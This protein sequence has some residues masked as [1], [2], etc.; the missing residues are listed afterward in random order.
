MNIIALIVT[1]LATIKYLDSIANRLYL[2][3]M[4][5]SDSIVEKLLTAS[6]KVTAEQL[7]SMHDQVKTTKK[8]LADL[9][10]SS[11]LTTEAELT[12]F[13]AQEVDVPYVDL[14]P[15]EIDSEILHTVPE[16]TAK[17]YRVV[18]FGQTPSGAKK[19]AIEDPDDVQAVNFL[20]KTF[21]SNLQLY[22]ANSS[23]ISASLDL[24]RGNI[25][26]ELIKVISNDDSSEPVE[27]EVSEADVAEDSPI[28]QTVNLLIEDAVKQGASDIHIEPR[29]L[30]VL[31][32][33]RVDGMLREANKLPKKVHN[34]LVSRI[35]ILSNLKIDERRAP[36]DGRF[37]V[38][39]GG[40]VYAMRVS[41]LPVA[42]GE[43]VAMRILNESSKPSTLQELGFWGTSLRAIN[44][45]ITKP[46]GMVLVTG[47]TG[48]GKSTSLFSILSILNKPAVNISTIEDPI[49]YR[50]PGTN[51]TQVNPVAHMTFASG[52][53]ALLRQD[54]NIIM[55]GEIRDT[56]TAGLAVQAALTGHLVFSTLHTNNAA[57]SLP[58]LLDMGVEA[59]LIASTVRAVVG[60]RLVRKLCVDCRQSY[61][62][63]SAALAELDDVFHINNPDAIAE[64]HR[65]ESE[66]R[67][68]GIG[69]ISKPKSSSTVDRNARR[70]P[71]PAQ[72]DS[73][74]ADTPLGTSESA[75]T[76]LWQANA[77][78][79]QTC[80]HTGFK[81]RIGIYEV[82][83]NSPSIQK[84]IIGNHSS[85]ELQAQAISEGMLPIQMDGLI[86]ALRGMT[87]IEEILRVTAEA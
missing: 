50:I 2:F 51:Q 23:A 75:I 21:G 48:S 25:S 83:D 15:L 22:V 66:A 5:I 81:G 41:T 49:E 31:V 85:E 78:G 3:C 11:N 26:S 7:A 68:A 40:H 37:K 54:P 17:Q 46:H 62:P 58:R 1:H 16:R 60:Q 79:C 12:R 76:T 19:L 71:E 67:A 14:N 38:E 42:D 35:K 34:A 69:A 28:A 32:R 24:Y 18:A 87:T 57:T 74:L 72:N 29:D 10:V 30:L 52:L 86:K 4:H 56:E 73:Q 45:S 82:L 43:K 8:S 61:A 84:L 77:E 33:Y 80:N 27:Q 64:L 55:V 44:K 65:L 13:Y 36:Q 59:F 70:T 9:A 47:P 6:H 20:R 63:S 53:R 39:I